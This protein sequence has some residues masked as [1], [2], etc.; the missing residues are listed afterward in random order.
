MSDLLDAADPAGRPPVLDEHKRRTIIAMLANGSSRRMAANYVAAPPPRWPAP[1]SATP[2]SPPPP[3]AEQNTEIDALRRVRHA[4][5]NERNWRAAAWLLER[6]NPQDFAQHPPQAFTDQQLVQLF[7]IAVDP[8]IEKMSDDDFDQAMARLEEL[9]R[10]SRVYALQGRRPK[11][12]ASVTPS[13]GVSAAAEPADPRR[14]GSTT[15][16]TNPKEGV[17]HQTTPMS[18]ATRGKNRRRNTYVV[19]AFQTIPTLPPITVA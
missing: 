7:I 10:Q 2:S 5:R 1:C 13:G 11:I 19:E 3:W 4:S 16:R 17:S 18:R 8:F 12:P 6:R 14:R 9:I 15:T